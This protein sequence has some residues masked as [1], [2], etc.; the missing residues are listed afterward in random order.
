MT[1]RRIRFPLFTCCLKCTCI[2]LLL[3]D[4]PDSDRSGH[5]LWVKNLLRLIASKYTCNHAH[6]LCLLCPQ[7]FTSK[8]FLDEHDELL[9]TCLATM[10]MLDRQQVKLRF[11]R[12]HYW[13]LIKFCLV[14]DWVFSYAG[15]ATTCQH[16][17]RPR[18]LCPSHEATQKLSNRPC[19]PNVIGKFFDPVFAQGNTIGEILSQNVQMHPLRVAQRMQLGQVMTCNNCHEQL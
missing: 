2:I 8:P 7:A 9:S 14:A 1:K 5:Y 18:F 6:H 11:D 16:A 12:H 15:S 10:H 17:H 4:L 19:H 3:L 13:F